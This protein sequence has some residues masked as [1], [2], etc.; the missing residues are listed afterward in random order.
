[1]TSYRSIQQKSTGRWLD[2]VFK[3]ENG[4]SVRPEQHRA[5]VSKG[6]N[7]PEA[8]L[9]VVD[10]QSDQRTGTRIEGPRPVD[11]DL[12]W[13]QNVATILNNT[14]VIADDAQRQAIAF[15]VGAAPLTIPAGQAAKESDI[16]R[17]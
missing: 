8:D 3:S 14:T 9:Q 13:R 4:F 2:V 10:G 15:L 1:M 6:W 12:P 17:R 16:K 5:D 11:A 7:I